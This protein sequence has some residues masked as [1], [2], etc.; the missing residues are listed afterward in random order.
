MGKKK[1]DSKLFT[2]S[3]GSFDVSVRESKS[4]EVNAQSITFHLSFLNGEATATPFESYLRQ[5]KIDRGTQRRL[6]RKGCGFPF[7]L[8]RERY[9][10]Q[11]LSSMQRGSSDF[12][13][14]IAAKGWRDRV[15]CS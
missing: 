1:T 6:T 8:E 9:S 11:P 3:L 2:L 4:G 13:Y 5:T 14:L 10:Q 7:F 12:A 15:D